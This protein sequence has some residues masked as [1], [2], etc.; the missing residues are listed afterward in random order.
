MLFTLFS[1]FCFLLPQLLINM[2]VVLDYLLYMKACTFGF[3]SACSLMQTAGESK[4][5]GCQSKAGR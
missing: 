4:A 5:W 2:I 1:F 3:V